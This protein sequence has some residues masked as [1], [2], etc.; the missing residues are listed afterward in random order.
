MQI[1]EP[2]AVE[3]RDLVHQLYSAFPSGAAFEG[4][5]KIL[6][7]R[8]HLEDV[9]VTRYSRD[10]GIDLTARRTGLEE[11]SR[12]DEVRYVVQAKRYTP[13]STVP[14]ET[15]R[16]LRGVLEA[17]DKGLFIT[18]GKFSSGAAAFAESD[19][20]RPIVLIDGERLVNLCIQHY[21]GFHFRPIF[22]SQS[23]Y[24]QIQ[25]II[26]ASSGTIRETPTATSFI[27]TITA[28]DIRARIISVPSDLALLIPA[29]SETVS[30]CFPPH[31]PTKEY[32]Y[33]HDR[34]YFAGVTD[35]LLKFGLLGADGERI[36]RIAEWV[37]HADSGLITVQIGGSP[38]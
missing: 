14:I 28:N 2:S 11:L 5:L 38:G 33:R 6:L 17:N 10:G 9:A 19:P 12:I 30:V 32:R 29:E 22:D 24:L 37:R 8:M 18:T 4:F 7:N 34:R 21:L 35:V 36:P 16:A 25:P 1:A 26:S 15:V 13:D 20:T 27:K 3:I 23:L 31:F